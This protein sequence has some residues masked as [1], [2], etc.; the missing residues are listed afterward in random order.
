VAA[1]LIVA[2]LMYVPPPELDLAAGMRVLAATSGV[3]TGILYFALGR[4]LS[5]RRLQWAGL[6][7]GLLSAAIFF[8]PL[9]AAESWLALGGVWA[10]TLFVS[11]GLALG[12]RL[13]E[14]RSSHG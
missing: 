11:G 3:G 1:I 6:V 2:G 5:L 4:E 10:A 14:A 8:L 9:T 13:A 7:G 12:R